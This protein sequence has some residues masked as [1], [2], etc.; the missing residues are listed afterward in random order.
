MRSSVMRA[1]LLLAVACGD[2]GGGAGGDAGAPDGGPRFDEC[3]ESEVPL[4][5]GGCERVGLPE[6][7]WPGW[8]PTDDGGCEPIL[9]TEPCADGTMEVIGEAE[10]QP[11]G[12][13]GDGPW[14]ALVTD[15]D[16]IFVDGSYAGG[17]SDGSEA[18]PFTAIGDALAA[19]SAGGQVVV[20]AGEYEEDLLVDYRV[21]IEGRCAAMVTLR[22]VSSGVPA[23]WI[24]W[25]GVEVRGVTVTGPAWGIAVDGDD[26]LVED[27]VVADC[28][29]AGLQSERSDGLTLRRVLATANRNV[30]LSLLG[31]AATFEDVV[32]QDTRARPGAGN[33]P[34]IE[35]GIDPYT[36]RA[37]DLTL[38]RG[39]VQ[40]NE[41]IGI[42][43]H[44][45]DATVEE[46][47]VRG[48]TLEGEGISAGVSAEDEPAA[49]RRAS[50][51]LR[52][53]LLASNRDVALSVLNSD[54]WIEDLV[55]R[56]TVIRPSS[57]G[58]IGLSIES[59]EGSGEPA[60]AT[61]CRGLILRSSAVAALAFR[62]SS[63]VAE[64][65]IVRDTAPT[66]DGIWGRGVSIQSGADLT[67][68][69][70]VL[71]GN[72]EVALYVNA[73]AITVE[74]VVAR[75]TAANGAGN[76]GDGVLVYDEEG[77]TT[78]ADLAGLAV[79]DNVRAG[80]MFWGAGGSLARSVMRRNVFAVALEGGA[81]PEI[82]DDNVYLDNGRNDV[83]VGLGLEP[84][85]PVQET[86][87]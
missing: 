5:G 43:V 74:D 69:R 68:R 75:D 52:R 65:L 8:L 86:D 7:C 38:R 17:K 61:L 77:G 79:E 76:F 35:V 66:P 21:R 29:L 19:A 44:G 23:L 55:V 36:G 45:A 42:H 18:R 4:A 64:E 16:T 58:A 57:G 59:E 41:R 34:G 62:G 82:S 71:G 28:E 83:A 10:C 31:T 39:V 51:T 14:G 87:P 48:T 85:P 70:S 46:A 22:G 24:V 72:A 56:D 15:A 6:E 67:L 47:V 20:A 1:A 73:A 80:V 33:G 84:A 30:G 40:G 2:A 78:R 25:G 13:C 63:V 3:G 32:A 53:S 37:G 49:G 50:L 54:A 11:I 9:P 60:R 26:V 27:T 12:D 81:D